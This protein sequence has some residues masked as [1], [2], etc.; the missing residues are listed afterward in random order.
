MAA[1]SGTGVKRMKAERFG[2]RCTDD[3]PNIQ[4]HARA[5][6]LEFIHQR[7]VD[8]TVDV[9]Q[10]LGHLRCCGRRYDHRAVEDGPVHCSGEFG[11]LRVQSAHNFWNVAASPGGV[12]WIFPLWRKGDEKFFAG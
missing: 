1:E 12:T 9:F 8:A 10:Q 4:T 3:L 11:S 5:K 7:D 2:C 6:Q